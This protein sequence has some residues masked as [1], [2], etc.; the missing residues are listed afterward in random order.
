MRQIEPELKAIREK[1]KTDREAQARAM[2]DLYK[3]RGIRPFASIFAILL[4]LPIVIALYLVFAREQLITV[5]TALIYPFV[6]VPTTLSPLFLGIFATTTHSLW[7][8]LFA[9]AAQFIQALI[10]IPVPPPV[11]GGTG[12]S[13]EEFSRALALQ[14]RFGL[15]LVIGVVAYASG[16]IALYFITSSLFGIAQEYYVRWRHPALFSEPASA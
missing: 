9:G 5:N 2:M 10:T 14:A 6:A 15:P 13:G 3:N 11:Q 4:Q 1:Y 12:L 8:A 7:L 16:A